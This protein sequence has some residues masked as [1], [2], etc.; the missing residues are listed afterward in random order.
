VKAPSVTARRRFAAAVPLFPPWLRG[1]LLHCSTG[2]ERRR[3][4]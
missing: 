2:Q 3:P 4:N 1:C